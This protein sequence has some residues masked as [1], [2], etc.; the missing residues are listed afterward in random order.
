MLLPELEKLTVN[1]YT[2]G[3]KQIWDQIERAGKAVEVSPGL[4]A[5]LQK[6]ARP[7]WDAWVENAAKKGY[8]AKEMMDDLKK[9]LKDAGVKIE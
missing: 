5:D 6:S 1:T 3:V 7:L 8:P 4:A 2:V 9:R